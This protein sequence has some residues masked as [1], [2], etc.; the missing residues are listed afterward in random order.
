MEAAKEFSFPYAAFT[1]C[2]RIGKAKN[3]AK[4]TS[5]VGNTGSSVGIISSAYNEPELHE[6]LQLKIG[7]LSVEKAN[8]LNRVA[9][10]ENE[11]DL[12]I[13]ERETAAHA[14]GQRIE[15]LEC[16]LDLRQKDLENSM[17]QRSELES[18]LVESQ[19]KFSQLEKVSQKDAQDYQNG[20]R[21]KDNYCER[22]E[23]KV[24]QL[25]LEIQ[26]KENCYKELILPKIIPEVKERYPTDADC[27]DCQKRKTET[28]RTREEK[29]I[30]QLNIQKLMDEVVNVR[31]ESQARVEHYESN[32]KFLIESVKTKESAVV[33]LERSLES[34]RQ[35]NCGLMTEKA[36]L[37]AQMDNILR[38]LEETQLKLSS[39]QTEKEAI[40]SDLCRKLEKMAGE[41]NAVRFN[42]VNTI[43]E[44][45]SELERR[46]REAEQKYASMEKEFEM[47]LSKLQSEKS[48]LKEEFD[49][50]LAENGTQTE[51]EGKRR[52]RALE[53]RLQN[54]VQEWK[55]E[56]EK[57]KDSHQ[58][59]TKI[60]NERLEQHSATLKERY[61]SEINELQERVKLHLV[62]QKEK[63]KEVTKLKQT[64]SHKE[65]DLKSANSRINALQ[66][67]IKD[68][69]EK[70]TSLDKADKENEIL[71][72][73][74]NRLKMQKDPA[75][76]TQTVIRVE[77]E[78]LEERLQ[79]EYAE[80]LNKS[81][82]NLKQEWY[83]QI[84]EINS[85]HEQEL[86]AVSGQISQLQHERNEERLQMA[87]CRSDFVEKKRHLE[88][89]I[90]ALATQ[91]AHDSKSI[92]QKYEMEMKRM[93][94]LHDQ[95]VK[96][97]K[98]ENVES[99]KT[100]Q[101]EHKHEMEDAEERLRM[102]RNV[103]L[104]QHREEQRNLLAKLGATVQHCADKEQI[105]EIQYL[106]NQSAQMDFE[107]RKI[108]SEMQQDFDRVLDRYKVDYKTTVEALERRIKDN[109]NQAQQEI[110]Q[111][112]NAL[113]DAEIHNQHLEE[114]HQIE[115][116]RILRNRDT[117]L[118]E[119][120]VA[121]EDSLMRE[122]DAK[123]EK[124]Q[125]QS[126][127]QIQQLD[128]QMRELYKA[129]ERNTSVQHETHAK[130]RTALDR[131]DALE[132]KHAFLHRKLR[133]STDHCPRVV[134]SAESLARKNQTELHLAL[135][136]SVFTVLMPLSAA[137]MGNPSIPEDYARLF[138]RN[139]PST[140]SSEDKVREY[141]GQCGFIRR[142]FLLSAR[143]DDS[144][145]AA[146]ISFRHHKEA[147]DAIATL[148]KQ[149]VDGSEI[150]VD[151]D[152]EK[153]DTHIT[154]RGRRVNDPEVNGAHGPP[155]TQSA[156]DSGIFSDQDQELPFFCEKN[157]RQVC[158]GK[159][160]AEGLASLLGGGWTAARVPSSPGGRPRFGPQEAKRLSFSS[161][162]D[163]NGASTKPSLA[164]PSKFSSG[165][166][167]NGCNSPF[168][169]VYPPIDAATNDSSACPAASAVDEVKK[170]V[171][172]ENTRTSF[173][174]SNTSCTSPLMKSSA[175]HKSRFGYVSPVPVV[176]DSAAHHESSELS[177]A[178]AQRPARDTKRI[179]ILRSSRY[180]APVPST[181]E[182]LKT[183]TAKVH[184][185]SPASAITSNTIWTHGHMRG[186]ETEKTF[187]VQ[188]LFLEAIAPT[189]RFWVGQ[190]MLGGVP[191]T[192]ARIAKEM[193]GFY[194]SVVI[195][196]D[197]YPSRVKQPVAVLLDVC[198]G[199]PQLNGMWHRGVVVE[200]QTKGDHI[201]FVE[202]IDIGYDEAVEMQSPKC[203][204]QPLYERFA[205]EIPQVFRALVGGISLDSYDT[206]MGD[207]I[208]KAVKLNN[209]LLTATLETQK[210]FPIIRLFDMTWS[211][212][213]DITCLVVQF[214]EAEKS[215]KDNVRIG[216][217]VC[218]NNDL[219]DDSY[220]L[221]LCDMEDMEQ[222]QVTQSAVA[223]AMDISKPPANL[224]RGQVNATYIKKEQAFRRCLIDLGG[225]FPDS[226]GNVTV[227]L[228][229]VGGVNIVPLHAV[230]AL[231]EDL[232]T[233]TVVK[234][235]QL[236]LDDLPDVERMT[237]REELRALV[238]KP[239][240]YRML[241]ETA[242]VCQIMMWNVNTMAVVGE[243]FTAEE[244]AGKDEK[245]TGDENIAHVSELKCSKT[246]KPGVV[247]DVAPLEVLTGEIFT[248]V[249]DQAIHK[250]L[251]F[252]TMQETIQKECEAAS[253][254][255][256]FPE[257]YS[258]VFAR[259]AVDN[260]W[261]R[262][263]IEAHKD[264]T[265]EV[266]VLFIDYG[267][268]EWKTLK[269]I[270]LMDRKWLAVPRATILLCDANYMPAVEEEWT[271][272]DIKDIRGLI[273]GKACRF[274][275]ER[276][277]EKIGVWL[278]RMM[279]PKK[280]G[281]EYLADVLVA[282]GIAASGNSQ[283]YQQ[284]IHR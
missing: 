186:W 15:L 247:V 37:K 210:P 165:Y 102:E 194:S 240:A 139:L 19:G 231:P 168:A 283:A 21:E 131:N 1:Q 141:F 126:D 63:D 188:A 28:E 170:E 106:R 42:A 167:Q 255:D 179:N 27:G 3:Q 38:Q 178:T 100:L 253:A 189:G 124:Y 13:T 248:A 23:Q 239:C 164:F 199:Y 271:D 113:T 130:L 204:I 43:S 221:L 244:A 201:V 92:Q 243:G 40:Q 254:P 25:Q 132:T 84:K 249:V 224:V 120:L 33:E 117:E 107:H 184:K 153:V 59:Y 111:L 87:K 49:K 174:Q 206:R 99:I 6:Q 225:K 281:Y 195:Q 275:P 155:R 86:Y 80:K 123:L 242:N 24:T 263:V 50:R 9:S 20:I 154:E 85:R 270:R 250:D 213:V 252:R 129:F 127:L 160:N 175:P 115:I 268:Q 256:A 169:T 88:E 211:I 58:Q 79:E 197:F 138:V 60:V 269:D 73:E 16:S 97:I 215:G 236:G 200:I 22:L 181:R 193:T 216:M 26:E 41:L 209:Q 279:V 122:N 227:E 94:K 46:L 190:E 54:E 166:R 177:N 2:K 198:E 207:C 11:V 223:K 157:G 10:L 172:A 150:M 267:N 276:W 233:E 18:F 191:E 67:E 273:I 187:M 151:W 218:A 90:T 230:H 261:Y 76:I 222:F 259:F 152:Y 66:K 119:A 71:T 229:D 143:R 208:R 202:L 219:K 251:A 173:S 31:R 140:F 277:D 7:K 109:N 125:K 14:H 217:P 214:M 56:Y 57:M 103:L 266:R 282:A 148:D 262:A 74:V 77:R 51:E 235:C 258:V 163:S 176:L 220:D 182:T 135:R 144:N 280:S 93:A 36:M 183:E 272:E 69:A 70:V 39:L 114:H 226:N 274:E 133:Q 30:L 83:N 116:Q 17:I 159:L 89:Q 64:I 104:R 205:Q 265:A 149:N 68:L 110:V 234:M 4:T 147:V 65:I 75:T 52:M 82:D 238:G 128:S 45:K 212:P 260:G 101:K 91:S 146:Y 34:N 137:K 134:A 35:E 136:K 121:Q 8:L 180:I 48:A 185:I 96:K 118:E 228:L 278:G 47:Q 32:A 29:E 98:T 53:E 237:V 171:A 257:K 55:Q 245:E 161:T 162:D 78:I 105:Q 284:L 264:K 112:R 241:T 61:A 12:L 158:V 232:Q 196:E 81:K 145:R 192:V 5:S 142:C 72:A 95:I 62:T 203:I 156:G 246:L 44:S 108:C